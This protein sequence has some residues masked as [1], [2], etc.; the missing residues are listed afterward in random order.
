MPLVKGPEQH[1][2]WTLRQFG[3]NENHDHGSRLLAPVR[4][5]LHPVDKIAR[6][7]RLT[8][9]LHNP[10]FEGLSR[11]CLVCLSVIWEII[12]RDFW[13]AILRGAPTRTST[14]SAFAQI[15]VRAAFGGATDSKRLRWRG[16]PKATLSQ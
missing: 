14:V 13:S 12:L 5:N 6:I 11:S 8:F 16:G 3:V 10:R 9:V 7:P 4:G 1:A 15:S 2:N